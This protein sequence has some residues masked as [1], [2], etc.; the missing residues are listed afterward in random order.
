MSQVTSE[1]PT[2]GADKR[3][4]APEK[5]SYMKMAKADRAVLAEAPGDSNRKNIMKLEA[6]PQRPE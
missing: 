1:I 5:S 4:A 3:L 2:A 6:S